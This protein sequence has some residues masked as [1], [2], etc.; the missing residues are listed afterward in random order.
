LLRDI[1]VIVAYSFSRDMG[2]L[3]LTTDRLRRSFQKRS[4]NKRDKLHRINDGIS[5]IR[6][7][8]NLY[9]LIH[10]GNGD[11]NVPLER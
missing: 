5:P 10:P 2:L 7:F 6:P 4:K 3:S 11:F 1:S 9:L 8:H